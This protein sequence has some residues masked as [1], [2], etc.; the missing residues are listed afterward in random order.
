MDAHARTLFTKAAELGI[1]TAFFDGQ[2]RPHLSDP[3][4]LARL[5]AA[6]PPPVQQHLLSGPVVV[7]AG[8]AAR[9]ELL[10]DAALPL[11]WRIVT[12]DG[13]VAAGEA[14]ERVVNW[15]AG[16]TVGIYGLQLTDA[17][18]VREE[19]PFIVAPAG[20]F[21]GRFAR[22]WLLAVQL[23][24]I[25]SS[26]NWGIGDFT[27]LEEII[28]LA[29]CWGADGV[30]LNPLHVLFAERPDDCSPY[31]PNSRLFLNAL[32]IDVEAIEEFPVAHALEYRDALAKPRQGNFIDYV[33]IAELKWRALRAAFEH[34]TATASAERFA[35]F[36]AFRETHGATL[37]R[38]ACFEVL[39]CRFKTP[40]WEWPEAWRAPD[41][42]RC[43]A[44]RDG[45]DA[46]EVEFVAFTQWIADQQLRRCCDRAARLG[47]QVGLY[48]DVAVGV[49]P[50]GFD[51][52]NEQAAIS[53][54]LSVGAP[55]DALN[56]AGQNWG[57]AGFNAAGLQARAYRPFRDML[58][59][60]MRYAGAVR[61]DHI[62][63]LQ[64][65]YL[66]PHGF[67][68][69]DGAY[70]QM[71]LQAL[72]AIVTQE[73]VA[74]RCIVI[75][76]DLGTVPDG[77]REKIA[78][79]G[80]WS[81]RVMLF[82]RDHHGRF[83]GLD[84]Y[85]D[86]SLVTFNTHDLASFAGW[87]GA[88][89]LELKRQ[90]GIDPGESDE[91]RRHAHQMFSDALREQGI[92]RNDFLG[93]VTFLSRTR[94][95]LL[96]VALD[97]LLAVPDQPNV[98]GTI[99]DHPNWRRRLPVMLADIPAMLDTAALEDALGIRRSSRPNCSSENPD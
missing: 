67:T 95:R 27:D 16:I 23:Y 92:E 82:E 22:S 96:A 86:N 31:S 34:F 29:S 38:F 84:R 77:F 44:L 73:S 80:I 53:R 3:E 81:Y 98:P 26:R 87:H 12:T 70:V 30:G 6:M 63:G 60:T 93:A 56:T 51:A 45:S 55:P 41:D 42:A 21:Q 48:L 43:A 62:L 8:H 10:A 14:R 79:W 4:A 66:V 15:P 11:R 25:R 89:D 49:Q 32:Y 61:L 46:A 2:G 20:A 54:E 99:H 83:S 39:R 64:R 65:L 90:L 1:D 19:V 59:A 94:S 17:A 9:S 13:V 74:A 52:W 50:D 71:P 18:S 36:A 40:W 72:L 5:I 28:E 35:A 24:S 97:D 69:R 7:R 76:E 58:S 57:L 37:I 78:E 33:A 75:G 91:A 47:M 85:A 88:S 68:A